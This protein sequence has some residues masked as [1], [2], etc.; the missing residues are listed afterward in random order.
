MKKPG[1]CDMPSFDEFDGLL[2]INV[3]DG[4]TVQVAH[5]TYKGAKG[6]AVTAGNLFGSETILVPDLGDALKAMGMLHEQSFKRSQCKTEEQIKKCSLGIKEF[7]WKLLPNKAEE[8]VH[9]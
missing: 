5:V 8:A 4:L 2:R 9:A 7:G 3:G 6:V 1:W